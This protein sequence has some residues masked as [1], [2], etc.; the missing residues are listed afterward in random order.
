MDRFYPQI[1]IVEFSGTVD[2]GIADYLHEKKCDAVLYDHIVNQYKEASD[3][4]LAIVKDS[5]FQVMNYVW[6]SAGTKLS[7]S[8]LRW[9]K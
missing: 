4:S 2:D 8:Y 6:Y 1:P 3:C 7:K 9:T 5:E